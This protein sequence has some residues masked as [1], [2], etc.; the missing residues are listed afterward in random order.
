MGAQ[1]RLVQEEPARE[2]GM[3]LGEKINVAPE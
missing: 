1:S 2:G 3:K